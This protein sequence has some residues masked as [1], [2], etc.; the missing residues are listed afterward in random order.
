MPVTDVQDLCAACG[1]PRPCAVSTS[2]SRSFTRIS[3]A[4]AALAQSPIR[5]KGQTSGRITFQ[6]QTK[7]RNSCPHK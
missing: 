5:L 3:S 1:K 4:Y 2:I 6:E 7:Q